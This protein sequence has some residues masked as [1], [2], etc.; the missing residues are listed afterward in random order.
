MKVR[1]I[2]FQV[3][4]FLLTC[5][6]LAVDFPGPQ[7]GRANGRKEAGSLTLE[8]DVIAMKWKLD[9]ATI[10]P[11]SLTDKMSKRTLDLSGTD[12]FTLTIAQT[13][14]PQ[15]LILSSNSMRLAGSPQVETIPV[16]PALPRLAEKSPGKRIRA[17]FFDDEKQL[18][19][20]WS[21]SLRDGSSYIRQEVR[22][23]STNQPIEIIEVKAWRV[24][25]PQAQVAGTVEG[26]PVV[27][28]P[29]FF[30]FE[31]CLSRSVVEPSSGGSGQTL[32]CSFPYSTALWKN[33]P[34]EYSWV[35][36]VLPKNQTR[37]GFLYYLERERAQ[38][39]RQLMHHNN[40]EDIGGVYWPLLQKEKKVEEAQAIRKNQSQI[41]NDLIET[42]SRELVEKR[43]APLDSFCHDYAW[44]D[45]NLV[46]QFHEGFPQGF[47]Q[48]HDT[49]KKYG[50]NLSLW[51]SPMG[52]YNGR[53]ARMV[54]GRKNHGFEIGMRTN[55]ASDRPFYVNS[56][57]GKR[58]MTRFYT[59]CLN[60]VKNYDLDYFKYDGFGPT[61]DPGSS[62]GFA[63]EVEA[64]LSIIDRLRE[65]KPTLIFNPSA[66]SWPSPFWLLH[67]DATWRN[68]G[69]AGYFG[70]KGSKRQQWISYRDVQTHKLVVKRA[71][72]YPLSS[73]MLHGVMINNGGRVVTF[74]KKDMID[75]IRS[76]FA[77]GTNLQELYI[78]KD[79]MTP[80][81]WDALAEAS[82]WARSNQDIMADTHWIGG[83]PEKFE[84]YGR[85]SWSKDK[86]V[87]A[88]RNPD[89]RENSITLDIGKVFELPEGAPQS[90]SLRS[91]WKSDEAKPALTLT[92]G[93]PHVFRL[94]PFEV[95]VLDARPIDRHNR[96][97]DD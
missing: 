89:D 8:N 91:P 70:D 66:G 80:E 68:G 63:S 44:D 47:R 95:L 43:K 62:L 64:V 85:A 41:W 35:V 32:T 90:Y 6:L 76:F 50:V 13:P 48:V 87:L 92:A 42:F 11:V 19:V 17:A 15:P 53:P 14:F 12:C 7:P 86:A 45:E 58:F 18:Q 16:R 82:R 69:D 33:Q 1:L 74:D 31:H 29:F 2:T 54:Q 83:D 60:M 71:P 79:H 78:H 21:A 88:L 59:A 93:R 22:L 65:V 75:E 67:A 84:I 27:S 26:S 36:G 4:V 97:S 81:V 77:T 39:Y 9:G 46:W 3:C 30:G 10:K 57:A 23:Q 20:E 28:E 52:G 72:L 37:R 40:G 24:A 5:G 51:I 34:V 38:P 61:G 56:I 96:P 25:V 94:Q 49:A 73:L 55:Q